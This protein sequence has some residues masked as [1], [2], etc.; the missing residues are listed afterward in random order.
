MNLGRWL[1]AGLVLLGACRGRAPSVPAQPAI[2]WGPE[3]GTSPEAAALL[4]LDQDGILRR[5]CLPGPSG[6]RQLFPGVALE[7]VL[8]VSWQGK[9]SVAGWAVAPERADRS[10]G[11]EL[12][13]LA[14]GGG[15]RRPA[16]GVRSARFSPDATALAYEVDHSNSG[17]SAASP[18]SFVLELTSGKV[19]ELG[20]LVDPLWEADSEHLRGTLLRADGENRPVQGKAWTSLRARW[21]R[22]SGVTTLVGPGSAQIPAPV[23][24]AVAWSGDQRSMVERESCAVLLDPRIGVRHSIVGRFCMGVADDREARWSP[25]GRWLAFAHPGPVPGQRKSGELFVDVVGIEGGRYPALA[26]LRAR[27]APEQLVIAAAPGSVWLDW[28]PS[29]RFLALQDGADELRVYDFAAHG[30]AFLGEGRRPVWSPGGT[31]LLILAARPLATTNG[32]RSGREAEGSS[33]A[34]FVLQGIAPSARI[35]L[36]RARDARWLPAR[37]CEE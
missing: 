13:V 4:L 18:A 11:K 27:A 1:C 35:D 19:T 2:D 25:D 23:G 31:Y 30:V 7:R 21:E 17:A 10:S 5:I 16:G 3:P 34:A 24:D 37:A 6:A 26:A 12:V 22:K 8:D 9:P 33:P 20:A 29:G 14:A 36:G 15:P 28:S 32:I